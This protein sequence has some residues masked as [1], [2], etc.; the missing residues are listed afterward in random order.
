VAFVDV[1]T[2]RFSFMFPLERTRSCE[3]AMTKMSQALL[4]RFRAARQAI[5]KGAPARSEQAQRRLQLRRLTVHRSGSDE[6][7]RQK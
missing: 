2:T 5:K 1:W 3:V 4:I 6:G 7:W